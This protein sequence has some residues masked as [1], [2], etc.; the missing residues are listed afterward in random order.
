MICFMAILLF[1]FDS[2]SGL[3]LRCSPWL[4]SAFVPKPAAPVPNF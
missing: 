2:G 4:L 1:G 3:T